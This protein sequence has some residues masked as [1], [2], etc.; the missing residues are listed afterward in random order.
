MFTRLKLK[1]A[2]LMTYLRGETLEQVLGASNKQLEKLQVV[3][4]N[5]EVQADQSRAQAKAFRDAARALEKTAT[6][7]KD[8]ACDS[9]IIKCRLEATFKVTAQDRLAHT[10]ENKVHSE[11][12]KAK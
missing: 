12:V 4:S 5:L 2:T 3:K 10:L 7:C 8:K 9:D 1:Y 11:D 6:A